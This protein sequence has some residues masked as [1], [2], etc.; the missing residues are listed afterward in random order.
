MPGFTTAEAAAEARPDSEADAWLSSR[1]PT[2]LAVSGAEARSC[3]RSRSLARNCITLSR[4]RFLCS[5]RRSRPTTCAAT[6]LWCE[7]LTGSTRC[8]TLR[9]VRSNS[10]L[11][12]ANAALL[13]STFALAPS[14]CRSSLFAAAAASPRAWRAFGNSSVSSPTRW[15]AS[16]LASLASAALLAQRRRRSCN[17]A[18]VPLSVDRIAGDATSVLLKGKNTEKFDP[19]P[20]ADCTFTSPPCNSTTSRTIVNPKP[21]PRCPVASM[22]TKALKMVSYLSSATPDP[23]SST[24]IVTPVGEARPSI[25]TWPRIVNLSAFSTRW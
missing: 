12:S 20:G 24:T 15:S 5:N 13:V 9:G 23:E 18:S 8:A 10:D 11:S 4:R 2:A 14:V 16:C 3:S 22:L 17:M 25:L 21:N 7:T 19:F 6:V 1:P